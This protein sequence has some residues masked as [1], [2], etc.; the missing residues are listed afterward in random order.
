MIDFVA[1]KGLDAELRTAKE[2]LKAKP[3]CLIIWMQATKADSAGVARC[4][5]CNAQG[6]AEGADTWPNCRRAAEGLLFFFQ[7]QICLVLGR[8]IQRPGWRRCIM[9]QVASQS[10]PHLKPEPTVDANAKESA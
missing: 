7:G 10:C 4:V 1:R 5:E 6:P 9:L 8:E 3:L 2:E